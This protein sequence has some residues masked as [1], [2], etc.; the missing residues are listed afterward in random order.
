MRTLGKLRHER[1]VA[2]TRPVPSARERLEI[3]KSEWAVWRRRLLLPVRFLVPLLVLWFVAK[4][5]FAWG[6][7]AEAVVRGRPITVTAPARV[8][9]TRVCCE[10][11]DMVREGQ[12]L[13]YLEPVE[14]AQRAVLES[15]LERSRVRL[16]LV[17]GGASVDEIDINRRQDL[18][19]DA[20]LHLERARI[21]QRRTRLEAQSLERS[22]EQLA[23]TL[24]QGGTRQQ[25]TLAV[26]GEQIA[27]ANAKVIQAVAKTQDLQAQLQSRGELAE[28][29]IVAGLTMDALR[30]ENEAAAQEVRARRSEVAALEQARAAASM[31][32][33]LETDRA[34]AAIA[35]LDAA[36]AA[37][38]TATE[39]AQQEMESWQASADRR[40]ALM[41]R[42][43]QTPEALAALEVEFVM[44]EVAEREAELR[45]H[46][47]KLGRVIVTALAN[48]IVDSVPV[49]LNSVLEPGQ[50]VVTYF[51][52]RDQWVEV[53]A[54]PDMAMVEPGTEV[55]LVPETNGPE[56]AGVVASVGQIWTNAPTSLEGGVVDPTRRYLSMR[57]LT[58]GA[59]LQANQRLRAVFPLVR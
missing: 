51:D 49:R 37:A 42:I 16:E 23:F 11:G 17:R 44:A 58:F 56:I 10:P 26:L 38:W 19:D 20:R 15:R 8:R 6:R 41:P 27:A 36:V 28:Q 21:E 4:V 50:P 35:E 45:A 29:G 52:P 31:E 33:E 59:R 43:G 57:V 30:A 46:D 2:P 18:L 55:T 48:G 54:P 13:A 1:H 5:L 25:G 47:R 24:Q 32:H 7:T 34:A 53:F 12:P 40:S 39:T 3:R 22:R 9:V 14:D